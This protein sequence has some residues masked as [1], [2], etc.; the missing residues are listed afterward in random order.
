V[1]LLDDV[2]P[3]W[4]FRE[5]HARAVDAPSDRLLAAA[6]EVTLAEMWL[7]RALFRL[8]GLGRVPG[9][10]LLD[11]MADEGF[12]VVAERPGRELVLAAVGKPWTPRGGLR[13]FD[14]LAAFAEPGYAL[15]AMSIEA[16]DG[17]LTTETRVRLT[18]GRARRLF[19]A[20]WLAVRP[21]SGLV[22]R[23]WLRAAARRALSA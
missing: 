1:A 18:D 17:R 5:R 13:A 22:R 15:M 16:E 3:E 9:G 4:D 6:R 14:D 8:R 11:A 20:Y 2:L 19:R 10:T 7:V 23:R 21:A 12:H